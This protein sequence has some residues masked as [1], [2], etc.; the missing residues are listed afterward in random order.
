M[1]AYQRP[2]FSGSVG[3]GGSAGNTNTEHQKINK[4]LSP[5]VIATPTNHKDSIAHR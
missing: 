1:S 2:L 3:H 4:A 5:E